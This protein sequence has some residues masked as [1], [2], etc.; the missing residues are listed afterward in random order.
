[1]SDTATLYRSPHADSWARNATYPPDSPIRPLPRTASRKPP[2]STSESAFFRCQ[3]HVDGGRSEPPLVD[4]S[5]PA[6]PPVH[7]RRYVSP[8]PLAAHSAGR[9]CGAREPSGAQPAHGGAADPPLHPSCWF[10][11]SDVID[12]ASD[13]S[14]TPILIDQASR[15]GGQYPQ[16]IVGPHCVVLNPPSLNQDLRLLQCGEDLAAQQLVAQLPVKT[17]HVPFLPRAARLDEQRLHAGSG[18]PLTHHLRPRTAVRSRRRGHGALS[19]W[20]PLAVGFQR[21]MVVVERRSAALRPGGF[22]PMPGA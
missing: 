12:A 13:L 18:Q 15:A 14:D 5:L 3:G 10:R 20:R 8:T 21:S 1:M 17:L 7:S 6:F 9:Q 22:G 16:R 19:C 4:G 11:T 2:G